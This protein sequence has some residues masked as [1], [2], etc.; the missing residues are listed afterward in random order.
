[1]SAPIALT[2]YLAAGALSGVAMGMIGV[3]GEAILVPLLLWLGMSVKEAVAVTLVLQLV[4]QT[5]PGVYMYYREGFVK[6]KPCL[7]VILGSLVG[8]TLGAY[9][10]TRAW[11]PEAVLYKAIGISLVLIGGF[12]LLS[13]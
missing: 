11:V 7:A 3:G 10:A 13:M 1:M 4:P 5:L 6:W 8:V 9:V 12:M 2:G